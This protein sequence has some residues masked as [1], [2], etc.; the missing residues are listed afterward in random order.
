MLNACLETVICLPESHKPHRVF[1][2]SEIVKIC[3][4]PIPAT[5]P[6]SQ[7]PKPS[8]EH[9]LHDGV[10]IG[11]NL[12][13]VGEATGVLGEISR[14]EMVEMRSLVARESRQAAILGEAS[15]PHTALRT[16]AAGLNVLVA[17]GAA[18]HGI[19][20]LRRPDG[21]SKVEGASH[22]L[23]AAGCGLTAGHLGLANPVMGELAGKFLMAHGAAEVGLGAYRALQGE[24]VLGGLQAAHG[25][26]L[27]GAEV[28]PAAA[29]PL[30]VSM[31]ALTGIQVW[32]HHQHPGHGQ[33]HGDP[34][35]H[36]HHKS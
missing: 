14:E 1:L 12:S 24:K 15:A 31:A 19:E 27:I 13:S 25:A 10:Q 9:G 8:E 20:L 32:L 33:E 4:A 30:C 28:F 2:Y 26:C 6:K 16:G 7:L 35:P 22:L 29:L 34:H 18:W 5:P 11:H 17:A 23:M 3:K 21:F 36:P